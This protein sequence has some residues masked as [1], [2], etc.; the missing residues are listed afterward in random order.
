MPQLVKQF[1]EFIKTE[2]SSPSSQQHYVAHSQSLGPIL[3]ASFHLCPGLPNVSSFRLPRLNAY[4][5]LL[6][7]MRAT[8]SANWSHYMNNICWKEKSWNS[9][10]W[11]FLQSPVTSPSTPQRSHPKFFLN[12]TAHAPHKNN[13][14]VRGS[15]QHRGSTLTVAITK[16]VKQ[17]KLRDF[18]LPPRSAENCNLLGHYAASSGN[19]LP[20]FRHNLSVPSSGL[21]NSPQQRG[22]RVFTSQTLI[23]LITCNWQCPYWHSVYWDRQ[24]DR[25]TDTCH[26]LHCANHCRSASLTL[27]LSLS[28]SLSYPHGNAP[29]DTPSVTSWPT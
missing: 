11:T 3:I 1:Q 7:P 6:S 5:F 9:S 23:T 20:T 10:L 13:S 22:S 25:Q 4:E 29:S 15:V 26:D 12:K 8:C 16:F 14:P 18:G 21:K 28:L 17:S 19:S 27:S 2:C 24:T